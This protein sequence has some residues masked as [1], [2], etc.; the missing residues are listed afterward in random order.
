MTSSSLRP[1][2]FLAAALL[3]SVQLSCRGD[4]DATRLEVERR[5]REPCSATFSASTDRASAYVI[6]LYET[7]MDF[8]GDS[9]QAAC[10][11]CLGMSGDCMLSE[12]V[13]RCGPASTPSVENLSAALSGL[14][15]KGV[16]EGRTYCVRVT[17]VATDTSISATEIDECSCDPTWFALPGVLEKAAA[18]A[19]STLI[20]PSEDS[21]RLDLLCRDDGATGTRT[22]FT[23]CLS[24]GR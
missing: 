7:S 4:I 18:C 3:P 21:A 8:S 17:E 6:E 11:R 2:I 12:R 19:L 10:T 14:R 20:S 13:C 15:F 9:T 1:A 16:D 23:S 24:N 22:A 5:L